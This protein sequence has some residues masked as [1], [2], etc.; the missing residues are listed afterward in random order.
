MPVAV[1][2]NSA[3]IRYPRFAADPARV[4]ERFEIHGVAEVG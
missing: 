3:K 4:S 2:E 1:K